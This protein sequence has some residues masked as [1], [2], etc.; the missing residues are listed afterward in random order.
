[1]YELYTGV[2]ASCDLLVVFLLDA[3]YAIHWLKRF[4]PSRC[5]RSAYTQD[6]YIYIYIHR[7]IHFAHCAVHSICML[8]VSYPCSFCF[9]SVVQC[10]SSAVCAHKGCDDGSNK[11]WPNALQ[12]AYSKVHVVYLCMLCYQCIVVVNL[13]CIYNRY[14]SYR[15]WSG[16]TSYI[17]YTL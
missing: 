1:M 6:I 4:G 3:F 17:Q 7:C 15:Y 14:A 2:L 13:L 8:C 16:D 11:L 10:S 5:A 12:Q 9:V